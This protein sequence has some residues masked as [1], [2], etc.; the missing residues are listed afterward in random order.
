MRLG[1]PAVLG[2]IIGILV[3]AFVGMR[4]GMRG[5]LLTVALWVAVIVA[6]VVI[7]DPMAA[8]RPVIQWICSALRQSESASA[9]ESK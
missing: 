5:A 3:V 2:I 4:F 7:F 8:Q 6:S 1:H 9:T